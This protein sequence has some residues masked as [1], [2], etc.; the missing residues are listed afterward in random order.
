MQALVDSSFA[1]VV[2]YHRLAVVDQFK[3]N[4]NKNNLQK[5]GSEMVLPFLFLAS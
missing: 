3:L 4:N 2:V 1:A 5:V